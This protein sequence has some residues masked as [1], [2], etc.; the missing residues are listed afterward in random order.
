[1]NVHNHGPAEGRGLDCGE[2]EHPVHGLRGHCMD[3][4]V[5]RAEEAEDR[6]LMAAIEA[7]VIKRL[8]AAME[9]YGPPEVLSRVTMGGRPV[10]AVPTGPDTYRL[11]PFAPDLD[12]NAP[13]PPAPAVDPMDVTWPGDKFKVFPDPVKFAEEALDV[14]L[15]PWQRTHLA[16]AYA[17]YA[18]ALAVRNPGSIV[19]VVDP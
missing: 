11:E 6:D 19:K 2:Y 12:V 3:A 5:H 15:L 17:E 10:V 16:A 18:A 1:M 4:Q 9:A 8:P 13:P 14:D 7:D